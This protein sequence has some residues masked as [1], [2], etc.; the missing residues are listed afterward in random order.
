MLHG[1]GGPKDV[2]PALD[3]GNATH[4]PKFGEHLHKRLK[5]LGVESYYWADNVKC[6]EP[7]YDD[8]SGTQRFVWL[9]EFRKRRGFASS[10]DPPVPPSA[11][12]RGTCPCRVKPVVPF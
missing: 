10:N 12:K 9:D 7:C 2:S 11:S 6:E 3:A 5:E 4:H 8:W 1:C